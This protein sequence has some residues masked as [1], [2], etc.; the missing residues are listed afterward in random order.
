M[1]LKIF[2]WIK[3]LEL[4]SCVMCTL[5]VMFSQKYLLINYVLDDKN[6][7]YI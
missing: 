4:M 2:L 6:D 7:Y 1:F 3:H 5:S